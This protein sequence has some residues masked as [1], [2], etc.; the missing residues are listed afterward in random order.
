MARNKNAID[1]IVEAEIIEDEEE[2]RDTAL[3]L[4]SGVI[5]TTTIML[6]GALL[7]VLFA[8]DKYFD[9]GPFAG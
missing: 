6:V 8:M 7:M 9:I 4:T 5:V 2:M 3:D 1:D